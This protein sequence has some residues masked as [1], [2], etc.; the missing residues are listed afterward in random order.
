MYSV[1]LL[2]C[3]ACMYR[4]SGSATYWIKGP[5]S[6]L[7]ATQSKKARLRQF[8]EF[9]PGYSY[10]Y[11]PRIS[12]LSR[13]GQVMYISKVCFWSGSKYPG[14][15]SSSSSLFCDRIYRELELQPQLIFGIGIVL[16]RLAES[17]GDHWLEP[18]VG[19]EGWGIALRGI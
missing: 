16:S 8:C 9:R 5:L 1:S 4:A 7:L 14:P 12:S 10:R 17:R 6:Q 11:K 19:S 3:F 15:P 2:V 18:K 13:V